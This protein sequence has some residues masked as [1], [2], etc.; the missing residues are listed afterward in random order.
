MELGNRNTFLT[1]LRHTLQNIHFCLIN[2]SAKS[3]PLLLDPAELLPFPQA[4]SVAP[5][6][7]SR[8]M[9]LTDG[10]FKDIEKEARYQDTVRFG[11]ARM[12]MEGLTTMK[13]GV[14][15]PSS[16]SH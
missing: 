7:F 15:T 4:S 9:L 8:G 1:H 16:A 2:W 6:A 12:G 14:S 11:D 5:A 10:P 3:S 13:I